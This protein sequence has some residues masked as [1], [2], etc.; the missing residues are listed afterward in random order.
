[1]VDF[2]QTV[3]VQDIRPRS[4][5]MEMESDPLENRTPQSK[6]FL[7]TCTNFEFA[8]P[9]RRELMM[10]AVA[11]QLRTC[12]RSIYPGMNSGARQ[13]RSSGT[14][15]VSE[16]NPCQNSTGT[17]TQPEREL[18]PF[19]RTPERPEPRSVTHRARHAM[20]SL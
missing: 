14:Q 2:E 13:C 15:S 7:R 11:P 5:L 6:T 20:L 16:L 8:S 19:E 18:R 12:K 17:G 3:D 4:I 9:A 10:N 1:M